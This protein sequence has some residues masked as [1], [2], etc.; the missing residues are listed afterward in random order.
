MKRIISSIRKRIED[1]DIEL[2][3]FVLFFVS[4]AVIY[5]KRIFAYAPWY[6]ELYTYNFFISNGPIYSA[7][8]W[9][10][11]N[12]HIG[13]SVLS[14]I[15]YVLT[16]NA[17]ISLRGISYLATLANL[18]LIFTICRR[19]FPRGFAVSV[20]ALYAGMWL[21]N[22]LAVQGR[23]YTLAATMM[24]ICILELSKLAFDENDRAR[25]YVIWAIAMTYGLYTVSSSLYWVIAV[26]FLA[27]MV[28][29]S[30]RQYKR[31]IKTVI[32]SV[33]AA[34]LTLC[35]YL[36]VWLAIGSNLLIK[37]QA[38]IYGGFSHVKLIL[39]HP[40]L[41]AG[42]GINYMLDTPYIQSVS[43]EGYLQAFTEHFKT[44]FTQFYDIGNLFIIIAAVAAV[45]AAFIL[46]CRRIYIVR[47]GHSDGTDD[48]ESGKMVFLCWMIVSFG[49]CVPLTVYIQCKLP[50]Y[51]V[52]S[53]YGF[54]AALCA[55]FILYML[56]GRLQTYL[57]YC[58]P[59]I[60][61]G[62]SFAQLSSAD[63]NSA[64]G[65]REQDI[66]DL[67]TSVDL[68]EYTDVALTDCDQEYMYRFVYDCPDDNRDVQTAQA[69]IIEKSM[70][71]AD[72]P[73]NWEF[74]F[75]YSTLPL[76]RLENMQIVYENE[77]Y[78]LYAEK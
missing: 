36:T 67:M 32:A 21:V 53:F 70:L 25:Y 50:Y 16:H 27:G 19:M 78:L 58:I 24:L 30:R 10:V 7:I 1:R 35:L 2:L 45:I 49:I 26:C 60:L 22:N 57:V 52:F 4:M 63:Y 15:V 74:Y 34:L 38:D 55:V 8:H 6:D 39:S 3:L 37:E 5:A 54:F 75:D 65:D 42:T 59:I 29:L 13:Y 31:L 17:F 28:F 61:I 43:R 64:Y 62:L 9:P 73:F 77:H 71:E 20:T 68:S 44:L 41:C 72:A 66:Y 76:E 11:P 51:R 47:D 12:N 40:V 48:E 46:I 14:G 18:C 23:G 33:G 56:F 69:V